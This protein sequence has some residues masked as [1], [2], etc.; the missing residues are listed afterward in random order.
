MKV[1]LDANVLYPAILR[2]LL[3]DLAVLGVYEAH[4]TARIQE[5]WQRNLLANRPEL[6][7]ENLKRVQLLMERALPGALLHVN[8]MDLQ[9][10]EL[11]DPDD[12]HVLAAAQCA[13]AEVIV[14][15]NLRDFP[16]STLAPLRLRAMSADQFL[17]TLLEKNPNSVQQALVLQRDRYRNPPVTIT[18][19]LTQL[20]KQGA[21]EFADRFLEHFPQQEE[22]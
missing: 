14:T 13:A 18:D 21:A 19:L 5:E 16:A 9:G 11:P 22:Q 8:E 17:V 10:I 12:L 1:V 4:W 3:M 2:S 15:A 7:P 6:R 20:S